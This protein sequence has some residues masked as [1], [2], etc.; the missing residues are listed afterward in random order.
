MKIRAENERLT[1]N[2]KTVSF[3]NYNEFRIGWGFI[4]NFG[5]TSKI[6]YFIYN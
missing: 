3:S 1:H 4:R 2:F 6:K 5:G